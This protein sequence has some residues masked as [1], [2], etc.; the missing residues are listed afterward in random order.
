MSHPLSAT[1]IPAHATGRAHR[2]SSSPAGRDHRSQARP[3]ASG[4]PVCPS[5]DFRASIQAYA[6]G[7]HALERRPRARLR[8]CSGAS[9]GLGGGV[10]AHAVG[11]PQDAPGG[12]A[13]ARQE[14]SRGLRCAGTVH[15]FSMKKV[16]LRNV[17]SRVVRLHVC[18]VVCVRRVRVFECVF[19][20]L[21]T[22]LAHSGM[23]CVA[24]A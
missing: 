14:R 8:A 7:M 2:R 11:E 3:A 15:A 4:L 10:E 16:P 22:P 19:L 5:T 12:V 13:G 18:D 20:T 24:W 1:C 21:S 17:F 6:W 9:G 23:W